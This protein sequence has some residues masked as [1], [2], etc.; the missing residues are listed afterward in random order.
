MGC[1]F[2][3]SKFFCDR[4]MKGIS[5]KFNKMD[6][7]INSNVANAPIANGSDWVKKILYGLMVVVILAIIALVFSAFDRNN[8]VKY[9]SVVVNSGE[10]FDAGDVDGAIAQL[11]SY[12][13]TNLTAEVRANTLVSLA[14][15]YAQKGSIAFKE[16]EY[17]QKAIVAVNES[18][19][20]NANNAEAYRVMAY[21]YEIAQDYKNAI[22]NY[23]KAV[24]LDANNSASYAGLGHAYDLMGEL[25]KA[26][27]NYE[28]ALTIS[29]KMDYAQYN[30]AKVLYRGGKVAEAVKMAEE[31]VKNSSNNRFIAESYLLISLS[32]ADDK[33][34]TEAIEALNKA[35]AADPSLANLYVTLAE[36]KVSAVSPTVAGID[37][38]LANGDA[39][40][41]E[42][43]TLIDKAIAINPTLTSAYVSK[44]K[45]QMLSDK[46]VEAIATLKTANEVA[47]KD[48]TLGAL[49]KANM[50]VEIERTIKSYE[51]QK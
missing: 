47:V 11:E 2:A 37:V 30:L 7:Q 40:L 33:K 24:S 43:M 16:A 29:P 8:D 41:T 22:P 45:F 49:E 25:V 5:N 14:S 51:S 32:L 10:K 12:L 13:E 21:A 20:I 19:K 39:A 38:F 31:V 44:A 34:M 28:K 23:D 6:E 46:R 17:S 15:A 27:L 9:E 42:A 3:M 18:L 26:Q 48:I 35:I 36:V 50:K 1:I 4:I